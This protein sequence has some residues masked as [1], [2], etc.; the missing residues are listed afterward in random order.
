MLIVFFSQHTID[1]AG[2]DPVE[3]NLDNPVFRT[4][5]CESKAKRREFRLQ[6]RKRFAAIETEQGKRQVKL[7]LCGIGSNPIVYG[8]PH[9]DL[10]RNALVALPFLQCSMGLKPI[11]IWSI[12]LY[13][14]PARPDYPQKLQELKPIR[15]Q[16]VVANFDT[17]RDEYQEQEYPINNYP[18]IRGIMCEEHDRGKRFTNGHAP[19]ANEKMKFG[20]RYWNWRNKLLD[21]I[22]QRIRILSVMSIM[23]RVSINK[24]IHLQ[25]Q[26][27]TAMIM[28]EVL[29]IIQLMLFTDRVHVTQKTLN[30]NDIKK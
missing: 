9:K 18:L 20:K 24:L 15:C 5:N 13:R 19:L 28:K 7:H 11:L 29:L 21:L 17:F 10:L 3:A 30:K 8:L 25:Y 2:Y 14:H 27:T 1:K 6:E 16:S 4:L 22:S 26:S 12:L 23:T